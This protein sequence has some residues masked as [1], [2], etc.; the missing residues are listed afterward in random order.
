MQQAL[1]NI[2][3]GQLIPDPSQPR[4]SFLKEEIVRLAASIRSRGILQPLRVTRDEE[5]Q[6][7][8]ILIGECRWR[9][10]QEAGLE[11]VPCIEVENEPDEAEVLADQIIENSVR[12]SLPPIQLARSL[13]KLKTLKSCNSQV[14]AKEFGLSGAAITRAEALLTLPPD[15]QQLVDAGKVP[16]STAYHISR[17]DSADA[18]RGLALLVAGN[19]L[20]RE[21][22][23]EAVQASVGK[24]NV[25]PKGG[26][27]SCRFDGLSITVVKAGQSLTKSD[28][29]AAIERLR[30]EMK[31]L[32][33]GKPAELA[34]AS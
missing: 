32:E 3:I 21:Q 2:P 22:V 6:C 28:L 26:R 11:T 16:E 14:L 19:E 30:Q 27:L 25:T 4:K 34:P 1:L 15:V 12:H 33:A 7:Y 9:A 10:A 31:K 18:Q 20:N 13:A 8:R 5:R 23:E 24:R 17:L 29:T